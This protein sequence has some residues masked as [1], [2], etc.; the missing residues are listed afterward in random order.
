MTWN[1]RAKV[2]V[3]W[4]VGRIERVKERREGAGDGS[5]CMRRT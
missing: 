3:T 1:Q 2:T 4:A 5:L